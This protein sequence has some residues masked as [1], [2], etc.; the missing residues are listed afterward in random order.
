MLKPITAVDCTHFTLHIALLEPNKLTSRPCDSTCH[1]AARA[2]M[3]RN[4]MKAPASQLLA[5][6]R[7]VEK[8]M[9]RMSRPWLVS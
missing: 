5:V 3:S 8:R 9:V 7:S 2:K 4:R 6:T 1:A